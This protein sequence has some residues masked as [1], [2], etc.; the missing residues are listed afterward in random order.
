MNKNSQLNQSNPSSSTYQI[1]IKGALT[2]DWADWFNGMLI[3]FDYDVEN[4]PNTV[5]T[6]RVRDQAELNG[7]LN[8]LHNMNLTLMQVN[9]LRKED[10][11]CER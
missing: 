11:E 8:W 6:C 3:S 4:S 9:V 1:T 7:I 5:L 10:E 2:E